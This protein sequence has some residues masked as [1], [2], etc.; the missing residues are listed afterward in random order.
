ML[1]LMSL[2]IASCV[3][4]SK[5]LDLVDPVRSDFALASLLPPNPVSTFIHTK[6]LVSLL[7]S[8]KLL[9]VFVYPLYKYMST[10]KE[11]A[12][13]PNTVGICS[14]YYPVMYLRVQNVIG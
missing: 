4:C 7:A 3:L 1:V 10:K 13:L 6:K 14:Y 8:G 12:L 5:A 2:N 11:K 9:C